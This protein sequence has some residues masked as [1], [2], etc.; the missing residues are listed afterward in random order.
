MENLPRIKEFKAPEGYFDT[1]P[2]K[3]LTKSKKDSKPVFLK[4]A[5]AAVILLSLGIWQFG[6]NPSSTPS[7]SL[8][9]QALLYI[10]SNQWTAEDVLSLSDDPNAILDQIIQE[11]LAGMDPLWTENENWFEQ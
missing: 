5:A 2:D 4:Y 8:E 7:L 9:D 3:I 1:L 10:E 6:A 11:E